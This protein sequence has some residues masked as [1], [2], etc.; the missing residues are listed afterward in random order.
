V[1]PAA[2]E[3]LGRTKPGDEGWETASQL[4]LMECRKHGNHVWDA[5]EKKSR[6]PFCSF[7][8]VNVCV[9][10]LLISVSRNLHFK[11]IGLLGMF[12]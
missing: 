6:T 2:P 1:L 8:C 10:I 7:A 4:H 3:H 12:F 5:A 11:W 9:Y